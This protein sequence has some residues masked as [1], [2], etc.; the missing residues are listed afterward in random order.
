L[1]ALQY[2]G[3]DRM[4]FALTVETD[5]MSFE[6]FLLDCIRR[7]IGMACSQQFHAAALPSRPGRFTAVIELRPMWLASGTY[8]LDVATSVPQ[9]CWEHVEN[10]LEFES[11]MRVGIDCPYHSRQDYGC[12]PCALLLEEPI[13]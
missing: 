6:L 5:G 13:K 8:F 1:T 4:R 9:V 10:A 2:T 7:K 3:G 12:G 11:Y